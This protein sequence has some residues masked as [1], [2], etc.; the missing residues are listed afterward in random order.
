MKN[1]I[2]LNILIVYFLILSL[3]LLAQISSKKINAIEP[4]PSEITAEDKLKNSVVLAIDSPVTI[5]NEKQFLID[6]KDSTLTPIVEEGKVY[7]PVKLLNTA[8]GADI[9]FSKQTKE[10]I[11]RLDNKAMIFSNYGT[12]IKL[13]D[14][15]SEETVEIEAQ[16]KIINDRFYI[17]LRSFADIFQKEIFYNNDLIIISNIKNLF[18]PIE[19]INTLEELEKQVKQLPIVGNE[20]NLKYLLNNANNENNTEIINTKTELLNIDKLEILLEENKPVIIKKVE[21]FNIYATK[22]FIEVYIVTEDKKEIFNFK[23]EKINNNIKDIQMTSD[24]LV[25]TYLDEALK[26]Y[27]YDISNIEDIKIIDLIENNGD[28]YTNII[29][30]NHL[31]T[32][33]KINLSKDKSKLPYFTQYFYNDNN[34]IDIKDN[35]FNLEDIFY[36]PDMND[37]DYTLISHINLYKEETISSSVY[38]GMGSNLAI[39]EEIIYNIT[40]N[41]Y[42]NNLYQFKVTLDGIE[43]IKRK[44][45]KG[46]FESLEIDK[47]KDFL[48]VNLKNNNL[49]FDNELNER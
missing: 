49:Y 46:E 12:S 37:N 47:E 15:T 30:E 13:L 19:E 3:V 2:I 24:R 1:K 35:Y 34:I 33:S 9:S 38:L 26:T 4:L 11:I 18:D 31:Y 5:I 22:G 17:P 21:G 29:D 36:F 7:I 41:N 39:D 45:V 23:I 6:E 42:N 48:K 10:T 8:F 44:F 28:F 20:A 27:V 25:I 43:Y 14:N 32:I 40:F 16:S